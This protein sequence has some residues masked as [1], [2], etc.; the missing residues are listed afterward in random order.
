MYKNNVMNPYVMGLHTEFRAAT[1]CCED[2]IFKKWLVEKENNIKLYYG[3]LI[4]VGMKTDKSLFELNKGCLD[5]IAL[6]TTNQDIVEISDAAS[7]IKQKNINKINGYLDIKN[8]CMCINNLKIST[9]FD[10]RGQQ[11]AIQFPFNEQT[12]KASRH[13]AIIEEQ[14]YVG[15]YGN[16]D[17]YNRD[18][19]IKKLEIL[20][21]DL[22]LCGIQS[23]IDME[24]INGKYVCVVKNNSKTLRKTL[25]K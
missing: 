16:D 12:I 3:F 15:A 13:L 24:T 21:K 4:S 18:N 20:N 14:V 17:D 22:Q 6:A 1:H 25:K 5:T 19:I 11:Y 9:R 2:G 7:T 23:N 8:G 10:F